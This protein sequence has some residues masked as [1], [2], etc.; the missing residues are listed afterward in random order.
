MLPAAC[1]TLPVCGVNEAD[2]AVTEVHLRSSRPLFELHFEVVQRRVGHEHGAAQFQQRRG[3]D[4]LHV[5]PQVA[6]AVA[7]I[8]KPPAARPLLER[9]LHRFAFRRFGETFTEPVHHA[10]ENVSNVRLNINAL[11]R[12]QRQIVDCHKYVLSL[13]ATL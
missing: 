4:H 6:D 12:I 1:H 2:G 3:L 13:Y 9:H 10:A 5:S 7:A 11:C 8:A